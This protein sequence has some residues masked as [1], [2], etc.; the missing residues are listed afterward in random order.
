MGGSLT[1]PDL[2]DYGVAKPLLARQLVRVRHPDTHMY[3]YTHMHSR[4]TYCNKLIFAAV[5]SVPR[6]AY[7]SIDL[8]WEQARL[9]A[10][11]RNVSPSI[12]HMYN[13]YM[14]K[15]TYIHAC[16][17][18][19]HTSYMCCSSPSFSTISAFPL[20]F[21]AE[22]VPDRTH[23]NAFCTPSIAQAQN[24]HVS[25]LNFRVQIE[26][27][28]LCICMY[29]RTILGSRRPAPLL[30]PLLLL[31]LSLASRGRAALPPMDST[32]L[33]ELSGIRVLRLSAQI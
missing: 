1:H 6:V 10:S 22:A 33:L 24:A 19:Y 25:R 30:T 5:Q 21:P 32:D 29:V 27:A 4:Q 3:T 9:Y 14:Y 31:L 20:P 17:H 2:L 23:A 16:I 12:C 11:A 28:V 13:H 7:S 18:T 26:H 8:S 15:Y